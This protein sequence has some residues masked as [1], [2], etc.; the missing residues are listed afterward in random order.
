MRMVLLVPSLSCSYHEGSGSLRL[1]EAEG[2]GC[3]PMAGGARSMGLR[4]AEGSRAHGDWSREETR[5]GLNC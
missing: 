2:P 3:Q 4:N 1:R 5:T